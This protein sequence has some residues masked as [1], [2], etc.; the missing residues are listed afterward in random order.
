MLFGCIGAFQFVWP[1]LFE[2]VPFFKAR[3]LHVA[4]AVAWIFMTAIGGIY[5]Y[6]P[7][8]CGVP[9]FSLQL[10]KWHLGI[11]LVTGFTI[12]LSYSSGIFGGREYWEFPPILA[13]PILLSW[14]LFGYNYFRSVFR[15][16]KWPVYYW[17]WATGILFFFIS[18]LEANAWIIPYIS[19]NL[20]RDITL[21]WKSY[22]A[23]V[24]SWNMLVYGTS[25]L[26]M[27]KISANSSVARSRTSFLLYFLGFTNLLFGWAH[28]TYIVP[29]APWVKSVAYGISMTELIILG[30]IIW[31][32]RSSLD[33]AKQYLYRLPIV[34]LTAAD[35][36][37]FIN[38][39]LALLISVPAINIF[40]HG[41]HI[42]VAHAM[43]ST[44]G[45][46]TMI[47]LASVCFVLW[48]NS[49][50]KPRYTTP[51]MVG[52][53]IV[54]VSLLVFFSCLIIAGILKG[55]MTIVDQLPHQVIIE[56]ITPFIVGFGSAG[57][58]LVL[59]F[60]LVLAPTVLEVFKRIRSS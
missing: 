16:D 22:G 14:V 2:W 59:G 21:Q 28:H 33:N 30:R 10:P 44:I 48:P 8:H 18:Y 58:G 19:G 11:F 26:V 32:W 36:W 50:E 17:M 31:Q 35:V 38:L 24:G 40:T 46:N 41:T 45:I 29:A 47:L 5:H 49:E 37:V 13:I 1:E 4:L 23:L 57:V 25:I 15:V 6:L 34:F 39:T 56:R 53:W 7:R 3:P 42:T 52:F 55:K 12:L 9:L 60:S 51:I 27:E 54:N 20:V 43:G